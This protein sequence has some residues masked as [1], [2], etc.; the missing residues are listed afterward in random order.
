MPSFPRKQSR[1][2]E[3]RRG[4]PGAI[5]GTPIH[6]G[7]SPEAFPPRRFAPLFPTMEIPERRSM[8]GIPRRSSR[9]ANSLR[10]FPRWKSL[11]AERRR[12]FPGTIPG[13]PIDIQKFR[14]ES[15]QGHTM[16]RGTQRIWCL[17]FGIWRL[18]FGPPQPPGE[19]RMHPPGVHRRCAGLNSKRQTP[20]TK[21]Q[22][23]N[24]KRATGRNPGRIE[25][26]FDMNYIRDGA[27]PPPEEPPVPPAPPVP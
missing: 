25:D 13:S 11:I 23:P 14:F 7:D 21:H 3:R 15:G 20:N 6:A 4:F 16:A 24:I 9:R 19:Y 22:T 12:G 27:T 5:P 1:Q 2:R 26:Y 17:E 18:A 10:C 8:P